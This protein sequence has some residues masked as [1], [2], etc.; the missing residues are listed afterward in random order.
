MSNFQKP[1]LKYSTDPSQMPKDHQLTVGDLRKMIDGVP[2][3]T[4]V[5]QERI[6][7]K[8]FEI[9]GWSTTT[10]P[11]NTA[12]HGEWMPAEWIRC[13]TGWYDEENEVFLITPHY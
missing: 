5:G 9:H 11:G 2:D 6:E 4:P 13:F 7:D 3:D 10:F 8:Y 1:T 12:I